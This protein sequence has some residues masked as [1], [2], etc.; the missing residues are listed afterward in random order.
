MIEFEI[1]A[2][3][4]PRRVVERIGEPQAARRIEREIVRA[5]ESVAPEPLGDDRDAAVI[6]IV[7]AVAVAVGL[8]ADDPLAAHFTG[9]QPAVRSQR[10][11][12]GVSG[13]GSPYLAV[14]GRLVVPQDSTRR[15]IGERHARVV[16]DRPLGNVERARDALEDLSYA[17]VR[18]GRFS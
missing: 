11:S 2:V 16:P 15:H 5:V 14:A 8:V 9:V 10:Q 12:V 7:V 17:V 4:D 1:V 6:V 3:I 13:V 18:R